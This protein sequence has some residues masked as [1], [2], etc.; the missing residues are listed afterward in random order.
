MVRLA[1][2]RRWDPA[3][4]ESVFARFGTARDRLV[5]LDAG[6]AGC[7][8]PSAWVAPAADAARA[9]HDG[10]AERLRRVVS[11]VT[12]CRPVLA[13]TVD[14]IEGLHRDLA[15]ADATA[16]AAGFLIDAES[17][18]TDTRTVTLLPE[19]VDAYRADRIAQMTALRTQLDTILGRADEIDAALADILARAAA[20]QIDD[21]AATTLAGAADHVL[22]GV[23]VPEPP[24]V[25]AGPSATNAWWTGLTD[26]QRE[27]VLL[28]DPGLVGN[29][30]GIPASVRDEANRAQLPD[31]L[32]RLDSD[33]AA[34]Q[35]R[36]AA[37]LAA[38]PITSIDP[39]TPQ[40]YAEVARLK[41]H[42]AD[43]QVRHDAAVAIQSTI[44][45][46]DRQ[47][48]LLDLGPP[49]GHAPHA[50]VAVGNVDTAKHVAVFTPGMTTTVAGS[51]GG[52][53][54]DM[55]GVRDVAAA[56]LKKVGQPDAGVA[57]VAW[58]GY[59]APQLDATM[60]DPSRSVAS[61]A[62]AQAGAADLARFYDGIAASRPGDPAHVTA[63]GHSYG[64]TTTGY[65]LQQTS[66]PV[67]RAVLFG[68]P[69]LGTN[70]VGQLHVAPGHVE[71]VD[72]RKDGVA[73]LGRFGGDPNL[74][75]GVTNLYSEEYLLPDGTQLTAS[76]GHSEYLAP[77]T[78]SQYNIGLAVAGLDHHQILE[79]RI[80]YGDALRRVVW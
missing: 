56:E 27:A 8:P 49:G 76:T 53:T 51:V 17:T 42:I 73:D 25:T 12:G 62:T 71:I 28:R 13:Q 69:G 14:A 60:L 35:A 20:G 15:S 45:A 37:L 9:T 68:S 1:D 6:L 33:L 67:D 21:G 44:A 48:L 80:G 3:A 34:S 39:P 31:Q 64:S 46:P 70:D 36:L 66:V 23:A 22:G 75:P 29:R 7:A 52:Y 54:R 43:V 47:L 79:S 5:D 58:I 41:E 77:G 61:S 38:H 57:T 16:A 24:P 2:L 40:V 74:L 4:L 55:Q 18:I 26:A 30:D 32:G 59:D 63:L 10:V 19:Q 65:A 72:A 50:A 78:T 11:G